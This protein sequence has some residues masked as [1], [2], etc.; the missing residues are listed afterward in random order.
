MIGERWIAAATSPCRSLA[1]TIKEQYSVNTTFLPLPFALSKKS[2]VQT[3][4]LAKKFTLIFLQ[5][6]DFFQLYFKI[7]LACSFSPE[8]QLE[9]SFLCSSILWQKWQVQIDQ[10][11]LSSFTIPWALGTHQ[12]TICN[13][14]WRLSF[15]RVWIEPNWLPSSNHW[16]PICT[17]MKL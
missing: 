9:T 14:S 15:H 1:A 2:W 11:S 6:V 7:F 12:S 4:R 3:P 8:T 16:K 5:S 13:C 10:A 17:D